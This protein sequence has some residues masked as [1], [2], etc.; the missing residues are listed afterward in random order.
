MSVIT[1]VIGNTCDSN[2]AEFVRQERFV[3]TAE[4]RSSAHGVIFS[5]NKVSLNISLP[6]GTELE[7]GDILS[8]KHGVAMVISAANEDIFLLEPD[9]SL[10][11]G[12][13]GYTLGNLHRPV[14]FWGN[15][16]LTPK[17]EKVADVLMA[18]DLA[19]VEKCAPFVGKRYGAYTAHS[20]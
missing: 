5:E 20:H 1:S 13:A 18:A 15:K 12:V 4:E 6:R 7:D 8:I 16:I 19:F 9:T 11:W 14:R 10:K 3:L 17:N 2:G